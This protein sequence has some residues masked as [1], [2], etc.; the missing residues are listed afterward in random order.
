MSIKDTQTCGFPRDFADA[1]SR[2]F[3]C[4]LSRTVKAALD[5][6]GIIPPKMDFYEDMK[7]FILMR[8]SWEK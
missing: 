4:A 7:T 1:K 6:I 8:L 5:Q 3:T 2:Y